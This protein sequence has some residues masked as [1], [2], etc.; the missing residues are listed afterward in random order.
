MRYF[1]DPRMVNPR[2]TWLL[3]ILRKRI[4]G[5]LAGG[6]TEPAEGRGM[7]FEEGWDGDKIALILF[8]LFFLAS[9][10][11]AIL[12]TVSK[13]DIQGVFGVAGW[14]VAVATLL[15]GYVVAQ[16]GSR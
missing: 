11:F 16:P 3:E 12:W 4:C 8:S 9:L 15:L 5:A 14:W 2:Q 13:N 6:P 7:S 1:N 10:V